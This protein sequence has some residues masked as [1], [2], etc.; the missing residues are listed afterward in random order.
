VLDHHGRQGCAAHD[1]ATAGLVALTRHIAAEYGP[2][3]RANVI[4]PGVGDSEQVALFLAADASAPTTGA[5]IA[6][7]SVPGAGE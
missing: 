2:H 4:A 5:V 3:V 6:C 7:G 1:A